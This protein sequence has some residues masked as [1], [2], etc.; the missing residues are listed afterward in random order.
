MYYDLFPKIDIEIS[1][2]LSKKRLRKNRVEENKN[3]IKQLK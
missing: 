1:L 3:C 2:L